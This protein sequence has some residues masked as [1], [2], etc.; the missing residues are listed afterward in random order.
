VAIANVATLVTLV[1][2]VAIANV[3]TLVTLVIQVAIA[4][5][6]TLVTL[7]TQLAMITFLT[8]KSHKVFL[9]VSVIPVHL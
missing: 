4:N 6:E 7:V 2:Q 1:I 5:V 8:P 3:E 9:S